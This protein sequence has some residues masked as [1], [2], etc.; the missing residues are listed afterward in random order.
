MK[1]KRSSTPDTYLPLHPLEFQILLRLAQG[2]A[3]AY[4]IVCSIEEQQQTGK[5]ILPTNMYRRIWRLVSNGLVKE[6]PGGHADATR[7]RKHLAITP[8]GRRVATAEASRL[9]SLLSQAKAVG[10]SPER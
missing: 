1:S 5:R 6:I 2:E 8:L 10:V 9:R 4:A 3:H 7:P